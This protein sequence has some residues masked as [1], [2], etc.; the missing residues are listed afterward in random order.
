[1][2]TAIVFTGKKGEAFFG[3]TMDFSYPLHPQLFAVS[4]GY[5][6]KGSLGQ[7]MSSE[8]GFLAIG[9]EFEN[10]RILVDG[11][12]EKG[13]AGA[14]LYFAGYAD[15]EKTA[16]KD[17][18]KTIRGSLD[19]LPDILGNCSCLEEVED[20]ARKLA[21]VGAADPVTGM[22]APLH[23]MFTDRT[24]RSLVMEKT[25]WG[26]DLY[27]NPVGVLANSPDFPWQLTNLRNYTGV[28]STQKEEAEWD[29]LKLVPFGQGAG[30]FSLPGGYTSPARFVRTVFLKTHVKIPDSRQK[31]VPEC[32][33]IMESVSIPKGTVMTARGTADYTQYTAFMELQSGDYYVKTYDNYQLLKV[34]MCEHLPKDGTYQ[35]LGDLEIPM[36]YASM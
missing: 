31:I 29:F 22:V 6:W 30:T 20:R 12:N 3:R 9:Q 26:L 19:V 14:A 11:V 21:I 5:Q 4:A 32:F 18:K 25:V 16:P 35:K 8:I 10:L 7:K 24:G 13:V 15:F 28:T 17:G 1:M 2:C 33:H 23:W 36:E 34:R 27:E